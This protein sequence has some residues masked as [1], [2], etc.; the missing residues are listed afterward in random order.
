MGQ[1]TS[2]KILSRV[3]GRTVQAGETIYPE[4]DLVTIHDHYLVNAAR[5]LDDFGVK[6]LF[7]PERILFYTDHEPLAV[8]Q[9][10]AEKHKRNLELC[11]SYEIG[12]YFGPGRGGHGHVFPM[13]MGLVTPGDFILGY[14]LHLPNVGAVGAL[15]YVA[16]PEIAEVFACGSIWIRAPETVRVNLVGKFRRGVTVRDIAQRII[17]DISPADMDWAVVEYGGP[18]LEDIGFDGRLTLCNLP[19][20]STAASAIAEPSPEL[21]EWISRRAQKSFTP[22]YSDADA[23]YRKVVEFDVGLAE[24]QIAAPPHT[25]NVVGISHF[26]GKAIQH[27]FIGS[28]ANGSITDLRDAASILRGRKIHPHVRLVVT[29]ATQEIASSAARE[30][31]MEVFSDAGAMVTPA[32]CGVC[33]AGVILPMAAGEVS[34]NTGTVNEPGRLGSKQ[35]EIYLASPLSVAASAVKGEITDPREYL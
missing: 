10:T 28:C 19:I 13:E 1:T 24:P 27:A 12:R 21:L 16:G 7:K 34:I 22:V 32:G 31:L 25:D 11:Q 18:A 33:A 8:S 23:V 29:P 6:K 35:V 20:E 2:E 30:G 5:S 4:G 3:L 17:G 15:G 9:A 26:A 14:D